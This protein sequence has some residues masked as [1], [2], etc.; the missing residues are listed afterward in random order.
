MQ[1][2]MNWY[3]YNHAIIPT[4]APHEPADLSVFEH[5]DVWKRFGG[6]PL[7]ARWTS[8]FDCAENTCWWYTIKDTPF[9]F[10]QVKPNY[11]QKIRR[12]LKSFDVRVI[13]PEEHADALYEVLAEAIASY[14]PS[15][16]INV[17]REEFINDLKDWRKGITFAAF[18]Q[19]DQSIAGHIYVPI[20]AG[21]ITFSVLKAKPSEEKKQVNAA[22][23]YS[24]LEHFQQQLSEGMYVLAGERTISHDT[25][26]HEYLMKYFGFRKA[27]CW[28][29]IKYRGL[30]GPIVSCLYP[31]R[32]LLRHLTFISLFCQIQGV[33]KM[34]EIARNCKDGVC[35][36][37]D[38]NSKLTKD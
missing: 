10:A 36:L 23:I 16:R 4:T 24:V 9:D 26:I 31:I 27:Y 7:L 20:H 33:M 6:R 37:N 30:I 14:P 15:C 35:N 19:E 25:N 11:R 32:G 34:E 13:N 12:G 21:Y 1:Q 28:L 2:D 17:D 38:C 3:Y 8:H 18:S 29:N 22:L 5:K